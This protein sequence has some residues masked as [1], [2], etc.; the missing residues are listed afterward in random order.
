MNELE[1]FIKEIRSGNE[2][3]FYKSR[4]W[5]NKRKQILKRDNNECQ[6]CKAKGQFSKGEVVHHVKHL[7]DRPDL[8][9]EDSNLMTV[10]NACHE[11]LHPDRFGKQE[12]K[13]KYIT[14][15]RW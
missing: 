7:K 14:K 6:L 1:K 3:Y 15:E 8:V 4:R 11:R 10:C 5:R 13:K 9:L 2:K 12:N